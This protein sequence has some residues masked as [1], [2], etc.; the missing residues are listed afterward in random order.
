MKNLIYTIENYDKKDT[1]ASFLPGLSGISGIPIWCY[2]VNRGQCVSSFG[3][4]DKDH[5]IME[6]FPA[7]QA[8]KET[9]L[10]GFR[11]FVKV[12]GVFTEM[13]ATGEGEKRMDI[14]LNTLSIHQTLSEAQLEMD[15]D[16][17]TLP[18]EEVGALIRKVTLT[19]TAKETRHVELLDGMPVVIPYGVSLGSVKDM[20]H[21]S[22][23]WMQVEDVETGVPFYR[24]RASM[25]D[26]ATVNVIR[27]GNYGFAIGKDGNRCP[28]IADT[29]LVFG[30]DDS[31]MRPVGFEESSLQELLKKE[32]ILVNKYPCMFFAA[33]KTL[34]A[35]EAIVLYELI[36]QVPSKE[37][38]SRFLEKELIAEYF[39]EKLREA[40]RLAKELTDNVDTKTGNPAFDAYTRYTYMDNVLRGGYPIRLPGGKV[41]YVYSRK[42]GDQERDYNFFKMLPEKYSQG[43][44]NFRDVNQNRRMDNFFS[45]FVGDENIKKFYSLIQLDGY[46]PLSIE[47]VTYH[48]A[49]E[50]AAEILDDLA[51]EQKEDL[52]SYF[53]GEFTPGGIYQRLE[54]SGIIDIFE[55]ERYF[56]KIMEKANAGICAEF[57]EGYWSDHWTYN[58]DLIE[59]Y[60]SIYPEKEK[61]LLLETKVTY[62][63]S[64]AQ[65]LPRRKRYVK[66]ENGLRQHKF[67]TGERKTVGEGKLVRDRFGRGEI[68]NSTLLEKLLLLCFTKYSAL[69][70]HGMGVE[71]EGGKPGWYDAL[72]GM[73][74]LF[75]SSMAETYELYRMV[76]FVREVME[77]YVPQVDF[78]AEVSELYGHLQEATDAYLRSEK[79]EY[80]EFWN[81]RLNAKECYVEKTYSGISGARVETEATEILLFLEKMQ[82]VLEDGIGKAITL[83]EGLCP[84]YVTYEVKDYEM[85]EDGIYPTDFI[86]CKVPYFLE[87]AV[88]Y[89]KLPL[90]MEEKQR[91]YQLVKERDLYDEKL[92]MY[93][94]NASLTKASYELGRARAFTPGWLENESIWLHMEYKYLLE[95]IK[96]GMYKEFAEDFHTAAIPFLD[97]DVY[98][99]S[100]YENSSF[101]A[102]SKNPNPAYHGRGFVA[103]LS[104]STVEFLQ[105]WVLMMFGKLF[106]EKDGELHLSFAPTIPKYLIGADGRVTATLLGTTCVEY[107]FAESDDYFP[108]DYEV[109]SITLEYLDGSTYHTGKD[110]LY[111]NVAAD[112]RDG[113]VYKIKVEIKK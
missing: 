76:V 94:V 80:M 67:L 99:R 91:T 23:A 46:N 104:G 51:Q 86:P 113:R 3:V 84:T 66:T 96:S 71:M 103:R 74:A 34:E 98:G 102:S 57:G 69:D 62:Y 7:H 26:T 60:L 15:V 11:S 85:D 5:A 101:I 42:H 36:G 65:I 53:T 61:E 6:F 22:M 17:I 87:G 54:E 95:L 78:L 48:L 93:K 63:K 41:F 28:V 27:G 88:R 89:L 8:Y 107:Q 49:E 50:D 29:D 1:F 55:Q 100:I 31:L 73:P 56:E 19:N 108:G 58:L 25:A 72:N 47:K 24:V 32:Q 52:V 9:P 12:D 110:F 81:A 105:M 33:E 112:V 21:T 30:Y 14:G 38:L 92:G 70:A 4:E 106:Y 64:Q 20:G 18:G 10:S 35:G 97:P 59:S 77:K 79:K 16:Y 75:G 90:S 82:M 39:E 13:F 83:G 40:N 37:K 111:G 2:Y 45:N 68:V 44:G 109:A 43:N